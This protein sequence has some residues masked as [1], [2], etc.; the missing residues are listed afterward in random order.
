MSDPRA[1]EP[2]LDTADRELLLGWLAFHRDALA[3]KCGGLTGEQLVTRSVPP[4]DLSLL[5]L[6]RHLTEMERVYLH[7]ALTGQPTSLLYCTD[8]DP[9]GDIA[10]LDPAHAEADLAR[11]QE[12]CAASDAALAGLALDDRV[13]SRTTVRW[14][15]QK[16][17]G[18]YARHNGHA[19]LIREAIDGQTGE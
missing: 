10:S 11:W 13:G 18:E 16:V 15:V 2:A 7:Q 3:A 9:D 1:P 19:D 4:S 12:E 5:G 8:D 17:I 14:L 6:A